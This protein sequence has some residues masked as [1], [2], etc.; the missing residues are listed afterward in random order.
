VSVSAL[1]LG[2]NVGAR[3]GWLD[4]AGVV[5][6][7]HP[8]L[9]IEERSPIYETE[10]V[11]KKDQR[12]FLNQ[13]LLVSWQGTP[14]DLLD[15]AL[16]TERQC[17]RER[18]IPNGPRTLDVDVLFIDELILSHPRLF[19]PHPSLS[20]RKFALIPLLDVAP[21]WEHPILHRTPKRL[22]EECQDPSWVRPFPDSREPKV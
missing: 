20:R 16:E 14:L 10:P 8:R 11:G 3:K 15:L 1:L 22:L 6:G 4:Q 13:A 7:S 17:G 2:S 19:L 5:L 9:W 12:P 18:E 21:R